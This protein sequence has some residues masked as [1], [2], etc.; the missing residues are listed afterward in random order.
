MGLRDFAAGNKLIG[1][2]AATYFIKVPFRCDNRFV[3]LYS[4]AFTF[5]ILPFSG[6]P[7][8]PDKSR[9]AFVVRPRRCWSVPEYLSCWHPKQDTLQR[10]L[11]VILNGFRHRS[12]LVDAALN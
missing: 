12:S 1:G 3:G 11:A 4:G 8:A 6:P 2:H 9:P 7:R 5:D 10:A